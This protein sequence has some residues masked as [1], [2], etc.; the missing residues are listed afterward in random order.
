MSLSVL[1]RAVRFARWSASNEAT[2]PREEK[3]ISASSPTEAN[4][5]VNGLH[6][7]PLFSLTAEPMLGLIAFVANLM[8][9]SC[10]L[11]VSVFRSFLI[12]EG[13]DSVECRVYV[14]FVFSGQIGSMLRVSCYLIGLLIH[15]GLSQ[16]LGVG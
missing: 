8:S 5:S 14:S 13:S 6:A 9:P 15:F 7:D 1:P 10:C 4:S 12:L 16:S 2:D 11:I 3:Y